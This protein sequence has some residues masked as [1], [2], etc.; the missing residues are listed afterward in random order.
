MKRLVIM[1]GLP[2]SGKSTKAAQIQ[3]ENGYRCSADDY[4]IN[5]D[6]VYDWKPENV[7]N[8][9]KWCQSKCHTLMVQGIPLIVIDNTNIKK[10]DFQFYLDQ[11]A[12]HGYTVEYAQSD[13]EWAWDIDECTAR[14]THN[15][16]RFVVERMKNDFEVL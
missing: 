9:H 14:N 10:R 5:E 8:A 2:G 1:R 11:A 12:L 13:T 4:H 16:P 7:H 15:V 6:G 3:P